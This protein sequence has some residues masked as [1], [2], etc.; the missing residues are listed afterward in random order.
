MKG[1]NIRWGDFL[2]RI[3]YLF[4]GNQEIFDDLSLSGEDLADQKLL[5]LK[6]FGATGD[7]FV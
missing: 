3:W 7:L 1:G 6:L 4:I 5:R 2:C